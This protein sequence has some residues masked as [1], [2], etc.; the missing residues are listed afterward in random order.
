M[1]RAAAAIRLGL[2]EPI[3]A[4]LTLDDINTTVRRAGLI[5]SKHFVHQIYDEWYRLL[6][7]ALPPVSGPIVEI[8]SGGGFLRRALPGVICSDLLPVPTVHLVLDAAT[9]LPFAD[10]SLRAIV[11]TNA[12]H[13]LPDVGRFLGEVARCLKP[14]GVLAMI[15]PWVTPWSRFVYRTF[16]HEPFEPASPDWT[17][18]A[19]HPL[20][21]ANG[22][23]PWIVF[24]RDRS[25]FEQLCP[26]LRIVSVIPLMPLRYL[27]SG[28]VSV[29][30]P[31]PA[32][33]FAIW[34]RVDRWLLR[35]TPGSAMFARVV[36]RRD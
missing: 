7:E 8:G 9:G 4:G 20:S 26:A 17:V 24:H 2:A 15:E 13:H 34:R 6:A 35:L 16:H 10:A 23:M 21:A 5:Q 1:R 22:A 25:R 18:D 31:V 19:G 29:R 33:S 11:M 28:G 36:V 30:S 12:F 32:W 14:G 27:L 3:T